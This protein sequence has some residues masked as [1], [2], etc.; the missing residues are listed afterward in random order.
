M[1]MTVGKRNL[2]KKTAYCY[3]VM[4]A[5]YSD[6]QSSNTVGSTVFNLLEKNE[7][8]LK[9]A[10]KGTLHCLLAINRFFIRYQ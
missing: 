7:S 4:V 3:V 6:S 1:S 8:K 10:R 5:L 9:E 2:S